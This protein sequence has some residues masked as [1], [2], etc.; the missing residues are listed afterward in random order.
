MRISPA[1]ARP[2]A[3]RRRDTNFVLMPA[4][5]RTVAY[6]DRGQHVVVAALVRLARLGSRVVRLGREAVGDLLGL[7][8]ITRERER[9]RR[10][11]GVVQGVGI[12]PLLER[13]LELVTEAL[14]VEGRL[15]R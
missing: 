10:G 5:N 15:L 9:R 2:P 11:V 4:K 14:A 7:E 3:F 12:D 13:C 6:E 8:P 1:I